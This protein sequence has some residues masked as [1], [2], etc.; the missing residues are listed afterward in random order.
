MLSVMW[1]FQAYF[2]L[3]S[4]YLSISAG[5]MD[6]NHGPFVAGIKFAGY[7]AKDPG[8]KWLPITL[9]VTG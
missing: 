7:F 1:I 2:S 3:L 9:H 6:P 5:I 8:F 4:L